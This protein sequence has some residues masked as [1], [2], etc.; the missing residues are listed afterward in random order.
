MN[1]CKVEPISVE[2]G[3]I[4]K[5]GIYF[6]E[7]SD[8]A[9]EHLFYP[10]FGAVYTCDVPYRVSRLKDY[11]KVYLLFYILEGE[12]QVRCE[13]MHQTARRD[14][15]IFLDCSIP[16]QYWAEKRVTFQWLH[17]E[18]AFTHVYYELLSGN[19]VTHSGR[20]EISLL[21]E[22]I[23]NHIK[24]KDSNEHR[25]SAYIYDILTRL[26]VRVPSEQSSAIKTALQYM[27]QN[28]K[29]APSVEQI[30]AEVS[31]NPHYFSRLFKEKMGQTPHNYLLSLQLQQAK[32][33]LVESSMNIQQIAEECGFTSSTQFIRAFKSRNAVTP[34]MFRKYYNP[35]GFKN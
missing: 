26:T 23:L 11:P 4:E 27:S 35:S 24:N 22:N 17:F 16:H 13:G 28:Y 19:G 18:G 1:N 32:T 6:H 30:A 34:R 20:L 29:T 14:E 5:K 15:V 9:R 8:F 3:I 7:A 10:F 21:M 12:L 25:L 33:L 31:L 2:S